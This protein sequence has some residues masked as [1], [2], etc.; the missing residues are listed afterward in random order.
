MHALLTIT[1][2]LL[3]KYLELKNFFLK[4]EAYFNKFQLRVDKTIQEH[5]SLK[6]CDS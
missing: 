2:N 1:L 6:E 4:Y 3:Q 5:R